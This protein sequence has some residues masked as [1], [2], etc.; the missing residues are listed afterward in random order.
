MA[1][2]AVIFDLDGTIATFNLDYKTVRAEVRG[3]L[4]NAGVPASVIAVNEPIFDMLKKA[5]LFMKNTGKAPGVIEE[6]RRGA[7]RIAEKYELDAATR[8]S[9]LPGAVD[10]LKHLKKEGLKIGLCTINSANSTE[11]IL[12][13]F[14]LAQY[15]DAV[16]SRNQVSKFKPDPEHCNKT[17]EALGVS[18]AETV[19]VGDSTTDMQSA[20]EVKATAV[21]I[22]TGVSTR[23]QLVSQGANYIITSITDLPTLIQCINKAQNASF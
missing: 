4:L 18:S 16:V 1:I 3:V 15:F 17:L 9:L 2:K 6:V 5:E 7:L 20:S 22:P 10:T 11:Q 14:K 8:T 23:E 13:R 12:S 21:G 19:F